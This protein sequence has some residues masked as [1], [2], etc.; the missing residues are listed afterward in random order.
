FGY[1]SRVLVQR[2]AFNRMTPREYALSYLCWFPD[3]NG[4]ANTLVGPHACDRFNWEETP[5]SFY[6]IGNHEFMAET[7]AA[8][9]GPDHH[10]A[11]LLSHELLPQPVKH[12]LVTLPLALRGAWIDHYWGLLLMPMCLVVTIGAIRRRD[13]A[14][15]AL[16]LPAWFM[17]LFNAAVA[18]NQTRYNLMLIPPF[19]VSGALFVDRL[20]VRFGGV[21]GRAMADRS[22]I[23]PPRG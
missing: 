10:L 9:G 21:R 13:P 5:D 15:L 7:L 11:Y 3:G 4:L 18:V 2:L 22:A 14:L 6:S 1:D 20:A 17:L 16:T 19:A 23:A 12:A 8:A